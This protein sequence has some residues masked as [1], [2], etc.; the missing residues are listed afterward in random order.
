MAIKVIDASAAAAFVF[1]EPEA[2]TVVDVIGDFNLIAPILLAFEVASVCLKKLSRHPDQRDALLSCHQLFINME[3]S[4][5]T[6]DTHEA[7][8]I[9]ENNDLTVYDASYLYLAQELGAELI[10]LDKKL[11]SAFAKTTSDY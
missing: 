8:L 4:Y 10:T 2:E 7:V 9:A 1:G 3:I 11:Q 6:V 5:V